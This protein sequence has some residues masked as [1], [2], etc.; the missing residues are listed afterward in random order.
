MDSDA[1]TGQVVFTFDGDAAGMKAA[2]R[3][4]AEEQR[5]MAQTFVAI[6]PNGKDPC[7]L[8]Q[9]GGDAAVRALIE[10]RKPLVEFVLRT[11]VSRYDLDSAEGRVAALDRG[12]PLVA[13]IKDH[14]LRDEYARTLAG[15]VGVDDPNR[16]V[17]RVRGLVRAGGRSAAS[18]T[19]AQPSDAPPP[20]GVPARLVQVEREVVKAALQLPDMVGKQ[21]DELGEMA[22]LTALH[23]QLQQAVAAAG[24]AAAAT[25]GPSWPAAV[26]AQLPAES[27]ARA[28]VNALAVES[29]RSGADAQPRYAEAMVNSLA[30]Q[31]VAREVAQLR[32]RLQRLAAD[33]EEVGPLFGQ[34]AQLEQRRRELRARAIG[35]EA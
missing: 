11:T 7:E 14:A 20:S 32:S 25:P 22:F 4:F 31:V 19:P 13:M 34:L 3:A 10:A 35:G 8:R 23:R 9:S 1:F 6:A 29:L 2:E 28:A 15:L 17:A 33:S 21:F 26:A 18:G 5:F 30:E 24:G 27:E 16:V 12:V